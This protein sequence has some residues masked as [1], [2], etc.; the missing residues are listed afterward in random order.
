ALVHVSRPAG[1]ADAERDVPRSAVRLDL[2]A[3]HVLE[4]VIV[5][6]RRDHRG[7][8]R[9]REGGQRGALLLEAPRQLRSEM[10]RV[11]RGAAVAEHQ[12]PAA[13]LEHCRDA[14]ARVQD[15]RGSSVEEASLQRE[16][17]LDG[18]AQA[19]F[20]HWRRIIGR[21]AA[22]RQTAYSIRMWSV[23]STDVTEGSS[24]SI[25]NTVPSRTP[26][27]IRS[28]TGSL[29]STLPSPLQTGQL[30]TSP[31][32]PSQALQLADSGTSSGSTPPK[33]ASS[34]RSRISPDSDPRRTGR[35]RPSA[36]GAR[37]NDQL[38]PVV[39]SPSRA[40]VSS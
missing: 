28:E 27:G 8:G 21:G 26:R 1:G 4:A 9:Q 17:V 18:S 20:V 12:Q 25:W 2:A 10:L 19:R 31:P 39:V 32:V 3:E 38:R 6:E 37:R 14:P 15:Q 35:R 40:R 11:R 23:S 34:G 22:R 29:R 33:A 16:A 30:K 13:R 7:V 36:F 5:G 24:T